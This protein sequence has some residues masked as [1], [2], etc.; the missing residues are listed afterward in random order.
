MKRPGFSLR[1]FLRDTKG[2]VLLITGLAFLFLV[3]IAGA[4]YDLGRQQLVRQRIQQASD[5][6]ALAAAGR[7]QTTTNADR[8]ATA[9]A[10]YSLNY[11]STYFGIARP[12]PSINVV[13]GINVSVTGNT[14]VPT[15]FVNNIGFTTLPAKG[16]SI[17]QIKNE[18]NK[19]DVILVM[20]NSGSMRAQDIGASSY[21]NGN[22]PAVTAACTAQYSDST[23]N[24]W[25]LTNY[26]PS[27]LY[28]NA[29]V[30][31]CASPSTYSG[32]FGMY[33]YTLFGIQGP[34][35]LNALRYSADTLAQGLMSPNPHD[36]RIATVKWDNFLIGY[37]GF[38]NDYTTV[39]NDLLNMYASLDTMSSKGLQ[40]AIDLG[41]AG[42]R[43]DAVHAIILMTDG[44]NN[45]PSDNVTSLALC[46]TLKAQPRTLVYTIAFGPTATSDPAVSQFLSDCATPPNGTG[47]P[48]P[49]EN[50]YFF[51]AANAA[52]LQAAFDIITGNLQK[53]RILQ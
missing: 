17:A 33:G 47:T 32:S 25:I 35:R 42:F 10:I 7:D 1:A 38:S 21:L 5:A 48:K 2:S 9:N 50:L 30:A 31:A 6:G 46:N 37:T 40:K 26:F 8:Y 23:V 44:Y 12:V 27:P 11:P 49:N 15:S 18:Y 45:P 3:A 39:R 19:V 29:L 16:L 36:N 51:P 34:S 41:T 4:G 52:Q 22:F 13:T 20:D 24:N 53:V 14:T 28:R 43:S